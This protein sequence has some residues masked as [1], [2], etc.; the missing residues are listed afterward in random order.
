MKNSTWDH[1]TR[2]LPSLNLITDC[3][4]EKY[5]PPLHSI[6]YNTKRSITF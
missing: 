1:E 6:R 4:N 3:E 2:D 5:E